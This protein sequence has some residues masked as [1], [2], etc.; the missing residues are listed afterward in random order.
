MK[1]IGDV[2][3]AI[4][5]DMDRQLKEVISEIQD[6]MREGRESVTFKV[7]LSSNLVSTDHIHSITANQLLDMGFTVVYA[8]PNY[9]VSG[10]NN[11]T[12]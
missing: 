8:A 7:T 11:V 1:T 5:L 3:D 2:V 9:V 6:A 12:D 10:W 4:R